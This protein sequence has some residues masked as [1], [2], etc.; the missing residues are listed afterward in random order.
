M[1]KAAVKVG[2][3]FTEE[4]DPINHPGVYTENIV[5]KKYYAEVLKNSANVNGGNEV[6][7]DISLSNR[8][9]ILANAFARYHYQSIR[10]LEYLGTKWEVGSAE[11]QYPR[12]IL[13]LGGVYNA[14]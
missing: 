6:N 4:R 9:S 14:H 12:I 1:P 11:E 2:F 8:I 3:E 13:S 5:E 10:Y 7:A